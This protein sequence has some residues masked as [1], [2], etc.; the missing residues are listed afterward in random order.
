MVTAAKTVAALPEIA[1]GKPKV[2][3]GFGM[4]K[5]LAFGRDGDGQLF[6]NA[7]GKGPKVAVA[8]DDEPYN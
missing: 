5:K 7:D 6:F 2:V 4:L 1:M 8:G 3:R